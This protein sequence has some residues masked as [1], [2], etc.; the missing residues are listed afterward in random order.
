MLFH[1][2]KY[3]SCR[4]HESCNRGEIP[5]NGGGSGYSLRHQ[6]FYPSYTLEPSSDK[7]GIAVGIHRYMRH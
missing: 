7:V 2:F 3:N 6:D 5:M 4:P 1:S